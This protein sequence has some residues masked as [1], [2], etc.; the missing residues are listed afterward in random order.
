MK[1]KTSTT[2][3]TAPAPAPASTAVEALRVGQRVTVTAG[4][5]AYPGEVVALDDLRGGWYAQIAYRD[6][7]GLRCLVW[8]LASEVTKAGK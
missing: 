8:R 3:P 5:G 7:N 2:W 6:D 4:N 1:R